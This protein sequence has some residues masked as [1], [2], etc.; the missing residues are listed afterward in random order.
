MSKAFIPQA[1]RSELV[2]EQDRLQSAGK[3]LPMFEQEFTALSHTLMDKLF[4]L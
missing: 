4:E 1:A 3:L 2:Q